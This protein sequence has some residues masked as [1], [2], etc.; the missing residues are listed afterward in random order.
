VTRPVAPYIYSGVL[1][2]IAA[3]AL[4]LGIHDAATASGRLGVTAASVLLV[5]IGVVMLIS[6]ATLLRL[7]THSTAVAERAS[8]GKP[9]V[10]IGFL[11]AIV[12]G[13]Y[14]FFAALGGTGVQ[15]LLVL[16]TALL[17]MA[18]GLLGLRSFGRNT[19]LTAVRVEGAIALGVVGLVAGA[20]QF[21]FQNQ[22]VPSH[23]GRAV[24]LHASLSRVADQG[25]FHVIRAKVEFQ[26]VGG[27]SV[28]VVGSAYTL[29]G[30]RIVTC[31]R[32]A[33]PA[34]VRQVFGGFLVDPQT[35]RY[36]TD[37][38]EE[39]PSTV[40]AAGKFVGDGKRLDPDVPAGR[41]LAF[42]VPRGE[43][44]LLRF[45]AQLFAIPASVRLAKGAL[46]QF[47]Q[48]A[49]DNELYAFWRVVDESWLHA[50]I[51]GRARWVVIR[52][53]LVDP[54]H[55][56]SPLV[57]TA[58]RATARFPDPTWHRGEPSGDLVERLF[59]QPQPSE[60]SEPFADTELALERVAM[61]SANDPAACGGG[62]RR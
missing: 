41:E 59:T 49:G 15:R 44:Q 58:L 26:D 9:V 38:W 36:M 48:F 24:A 6:A 7:E 60:S 46:P 29:T 3:A 40:L 30:S 8:N 51:Y 55:K 42:F 37:V 13:I 17:L 61:P 16:T 11:L 62:T 19:R 34:R 20:A 53:E 54:D 1:G 27:R 25:G 32:P 52:Y 39:R 50:L 5:V 23:A 56:E 47:V 31:H 21:W 35:S 33:T 12:L 28:T 10:L 45:R 2:A 22:Y 57:A 18:L 4:V 43:Y 14:V